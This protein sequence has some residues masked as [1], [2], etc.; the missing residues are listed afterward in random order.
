MRCANIPG[1]CYLRMIPSEGAVTRVPQCLP[2]WQ[3]F[4]DVVTADI[5]DSD[6][7]LVKE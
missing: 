1:F 3:R 7:P 5:N 6:H 4:R 2:C